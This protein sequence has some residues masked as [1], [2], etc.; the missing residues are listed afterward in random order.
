[1]INVNYAQVK[2]QDYLA[3]FDYENCV[4]TQMDKCLRHLI[5]EISN[6]TMYQ[7]SMQQMGIDQS[8]M[9]VSNIKKDTIIKAKKILGEIASAIKGLDDLRQR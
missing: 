2:H 9:P 1:M 3:P 4:K 5:E 7:R 6:V 8:Q